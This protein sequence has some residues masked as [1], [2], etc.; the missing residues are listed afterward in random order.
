MSSKRKLLSDKDRRAQRRS[1]KFLKASHGGAG[2]ER[3]PIAR[4]LAT[5]KYHQ[6]VIERKRVDGEEGSFF[7]DRYY[8]D[9][10]DW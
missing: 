3:N 10:V 6:R 8:E 1:L 2:S 4:D 7:A 5:A 9:E